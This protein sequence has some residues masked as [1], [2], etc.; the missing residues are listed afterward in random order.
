MVKQIQLNNKPT[1][2]CIM[3]QTDDADVK[4]QNQIKENTNRTK[5]KD[6]FNKFIMNY[7]VNDILQYCYK[8]MLE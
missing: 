8:G 1:L 2:Q 6:Q 5:N 3:A 7:K 4:T